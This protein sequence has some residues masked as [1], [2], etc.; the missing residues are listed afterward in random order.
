V[1][2]GKEYLSTWD[3]NNRLAGV[4][5]GNTTTVF[6]HGGDGTRRSL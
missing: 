4:T 5:Q 1:A 2:D 6:G 3:V